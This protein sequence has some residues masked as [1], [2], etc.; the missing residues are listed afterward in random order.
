[1]T[2]LLQCT[3]RQ[4][5]DGKL[6]D[7]RSMRGDTTAPSIISQRVC[8]GEWWSFLFTVRE[9][10]GRQRVTGPRIDTKEVCVEQAPAGRDYCSFR[11]WLNGF[12]SLKR[13][14]PPGGAGP[15]TRG[16]A[17]RWTHPGLLSDVAW[18]D[19]WCE[20]HWHWQPQRDISCCVGL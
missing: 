4:L 5:C 20:R 13:Y 17:N 9:L 19:C 2:R 1:M 3:E 8:A 15:Q 16:L 6:C 12:P 14:P 7:L 18:W 10:Q 11:H